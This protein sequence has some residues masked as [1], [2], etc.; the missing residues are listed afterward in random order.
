MNELRRADLSSVSVIIVTY[1][2]SSLIWQCLKAVHSSKTV[3]E[4]IIWDNASEDDISGVV[5]RFVEATDPHF[6]VLL[7]ENDENIGFARAVNSAVGRASGQCILLLNPDCVIEGS[8]IDALLE[9]M[10][11]NREIGAIAPE[12]V[13]PSGRLRVKS[14]G[15]EPTA[16]RMLSQALGLPQILRTAK[17]FNLYA[18][19]ET[20]TATDVDW[21]SGACMF[22]AA[23]RWRE[24]E[25][26]SER[27]F[28]YAE[29]VDLCRRLRSR[30]LRVVHFNGVSATHWVGASSDSD[31]GPAWTLWLENLYDY[32]TLHISSRFWNRQVW[33][34]SAFLTF[35]SRALVY[36]LKA[37]LNTSQEHNW[38]RESSKF[39]DYARAA[40][41]LR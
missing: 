12:I 41:R 5:S 11:Q 33:K 16:T 19:G 36:R 9:Q 38:L 40:V 8:G 23:S 14:A 28:M 39:S 17:G 22:V 32:Y 21:V 18:K 3:V 30:G 31:F 10:D 35:S 20:G 34:Y 13:H 1:N 4:V 27:W 37:N 2:S 25:G 26:L 7:H 24:L 6:E 29:D 15:F